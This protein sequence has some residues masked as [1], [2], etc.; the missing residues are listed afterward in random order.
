MNTY[1][2]LFTKNSNEEINKTVN[3]YFLE[4]ETESLTCLPKFN[5]INIIIAWLFNN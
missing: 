3:S 2:I 1:D 5:K 4:G